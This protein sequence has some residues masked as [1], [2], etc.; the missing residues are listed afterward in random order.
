MAQFVERRENKAKHLP[1][2]V[3]HRRLV[4]WKRIP[5]NPAGNGSFSPIGA[6]RGAKVSKTRGFLE[7][8]VGP[9]EL[10]SRFSSILR[11]SIG[12]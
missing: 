1:P 4:L 10:S 9:L 8:A 12:E 2:V 3:I 7:I 11:L 5:Q 6:T